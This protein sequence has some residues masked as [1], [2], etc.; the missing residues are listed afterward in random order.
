CE[1]ARFDL[2]VS[3]GII[4]AFKTSGQRCVS[5]GRILIH[6]KLFDRYAA[7]FVETAKRLRIGDPLD[8]G[9]FTGPVI[10][11]ASVEKVQ[12]Y[13]DLARKAGATVLLDGGRLTGGRHAQGCYLA[14]FVYRQDYKPGLRTIRE[15]VFGPHLALIPFKDDDQAVRIYNDTE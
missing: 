8:A 12:S 14:P 9:N 15:E 2:A 3:A 5:A 6:E 10:H 13:N 1:D 11:A 7:A 4:S